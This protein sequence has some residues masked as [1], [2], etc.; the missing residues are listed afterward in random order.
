MSV[1]AI[2][3]GFGIMLA[4]MLLGLPIAAVMAATG[5]VGGVLAF[6]WPLVD[7][8]GPVMWGV[9]NENLLTAIPLFILL[10][11]IMLRSGMADRMY[12][13][14]S[15][16]LGAPARGPPAHE[17]RLLGAVRRHLG[18]V[19]GDRRDHRHGGDARARGAWL[20]PRPLA[21]LH[22]RGGHAR[23]PHSA[24]R[25]PA[26][27]RLALGDLDRPVVRRRHRSRRAG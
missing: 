20:R 19:G 25:E 9:M 16:L 5:V 18:L 12:G 3:G 26:D 4:L 13:A 22:R 1:A 6:G 24:E 23:H 15:L 27:L 7:S 14:L 11:E 17:H 8:M 21:R 10:G 2:A